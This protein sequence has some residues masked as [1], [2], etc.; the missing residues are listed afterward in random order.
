VAKIVNLAPLLPEDI[1]FELPGGERHTFPG[2]PPLELILKIASL[3]ER[4]QNAENGDADAI[5]LEILQELDDQVIVLLQMR[6]KDVTRSPYGVFGVQQV[7]QELLAAYN[8]SV[9]EDDADADPPKKPAAK[10]KRSTGSPS[11]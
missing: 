4:A 3:F 8:F 1:I 5:G 7:V 9:V 6:D 10:S 11:S 2:D